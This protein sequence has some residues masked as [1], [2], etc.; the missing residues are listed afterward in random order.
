MSILKLKNEYLEAAA[1]LRDRVSL[2]TE[3][4]KQASHKEQSTLRRRITCLYT[5]IRE[6]ISTANSIDIYCLRNSIMEV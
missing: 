1:K 2:L 3:Q 5:E 4:Y 6:L